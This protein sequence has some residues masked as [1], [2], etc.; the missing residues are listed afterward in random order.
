M[1][2][3]FRKKAFTMIEC[4][5][6]LS[7]LSVLCATVCNGSRM[8]FSFLKRQKNLHDDY[9]RAAEADKSIRCFADGISMP[10]WEKNIDIEFHENVLSSDWFRGSKEKTDLILDRGIKIL[11]AKI[12]GKNDECRFL[13]I[14][15]CSGS[16]EFKTVVCVQRSLNFGE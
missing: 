9:I 5:V 6:S 7:V 3:M 1:R 2:E 10:F 13:E 4:L 12:D 15:F 8:M 16:N 11:S 14:H